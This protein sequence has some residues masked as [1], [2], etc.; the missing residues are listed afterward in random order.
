M[1]VELVWA[2]PEEPLARMARVSNPTNERNT[3]TVPRLLRYL[4]RNKHWS[5]FEMVNACVRIETTRDIA[6]QIIR[7][8]SFKFQEYSG[9]YAA[10]ERLDLAREVRMQD[11]KN[12]QNS[13]PCD[14]EAVNKWWNKA[15]IL[16]DKLTTRLYYTALD[17][18]IAK[19][20][21]RAILPEGL[22]PTVIYMNGDLRSWIHYWQ[23]RCTPETQR[24]HRLIAELTRNVVGSEFP[25]IMEA[26]A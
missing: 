5:P 6:H 24:E 7:H 3:T 12:R 21:A 11:E 8:R 13:L 18:G 25:S 22:V 1:N 23:V 19:E 4:T 16:V 20:V 2:A 10:Y 14:D 15:L 9:R 17:M 26:L